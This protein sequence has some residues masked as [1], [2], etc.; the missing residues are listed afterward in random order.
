[1]NTPSPGRIGEQHAAYRKGLVLGLTMAEVG[2]LII[3]VLLLL[4]AIEQIRRDRL[5]HSLQ[6]KT[7]IA[8]ARLQEL[9]SAERT[10]KEIAST[11][12]VEA[13]RPK[14]DFKRLVRIVQTVAATPTGQSALT[15]ARQSLNE[16][17]DAV[18]QLQK[19]LD[20]AKKDGAESVAKQ[21]EF[22]SYRLANQEGQLKR[23]ES[24]LADA[25]KGKGE[26]PCWVEPDGKI[27]YLYD[28][29]L[30]STGIRMREYQYPARIAERRLLP[31]PVV[32]PNETLTE[33]EFLRRT[34]P[35]FDYSRTANCR[36]F[37]VIYDATAAHEKPLY[38]DLLRTVEGHF[39][40]RNADGA[41]P[42]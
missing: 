29:V 27:D 24:Q 35:L 30:T 8:T 6:G 39:Y 34:A 22:A 40:K 15:A 18:G 13:T 41:A 11:L 31:M 12:N 42:F 2:I 23:Y 36:F 1:M 21:V 26:R 33:G 32:D 4:I 19:V 37:V 9:E 3:F 25:G 20:S 10:L 16:M 38:K 5:L 7:A 28:V 14:E 17:K